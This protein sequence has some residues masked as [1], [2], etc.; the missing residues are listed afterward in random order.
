MGNIGELD[1]YI[2]FTFIIGLVI[3]LL[4]GKYKER[5]RAEQAKLDEAFNVAVTGNAEQPL[6]YV[7]DKN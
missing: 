5:D 4:I 7:S 2:V 1:L 6:D 3:G